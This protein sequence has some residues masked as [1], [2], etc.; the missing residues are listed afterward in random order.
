MCADYHERKTTGMTLLQH[1]AARRTR[2]KKKNQNGIIGITVGDA[3]QIINDF[4]QMKAQRDEAMR[5]LG[6]RSL[7]NP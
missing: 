7:P 3:T 4:K 2:T 5:I 1:L 6:L